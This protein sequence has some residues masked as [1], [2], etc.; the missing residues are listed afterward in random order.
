MEIPKLYK[1]RRFIRDRINTPSGEQKPKWEPV[2][3]LV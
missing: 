1:Y 2:P 3:N